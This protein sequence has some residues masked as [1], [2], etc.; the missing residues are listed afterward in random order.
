MEVIVMLLDFQ[1]SI[2]LSNSHMGFME[3]IRVGKGE[4]DY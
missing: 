1:S 3:A 4:L 2:Q